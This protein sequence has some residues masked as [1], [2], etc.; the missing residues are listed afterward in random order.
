MPG[1][2]VALLA[3]LAHVVIVF[4]ATVLISANRR[5]AAAIAWVLTIVF[6]PLVGILVFLLV[7]FGRLP[8]SRRVKQREVSELFLARTQ[9]STA[10]NRADWPDWLGSA[11]QLNENLGALPMVGGNS[12]RLLEDYAGS[13]AAMA[14][15]IDTATDRVHV[16]FYI[17][18]SDSETAPV[19]D[20][21]R[22]A[23]ERGVIVR[24]LSD[25]VSGLLLPRRRETRAA[26]EM[27]GAEWL[28]MLPLRPL[29]GQWQRADMRNHRKLLVVD[30]RIGFT[31][32]Q[33]LIAASYLKPKNLRRGLRWREL[34]VEFEG[35]VVPELD[36][37]FITDWYSETGVLLPLESRSAPLPGPVVASPVN[38]QVVPSGPSFEND[39]N[40]KLFVL[41]LHQAQSR[42]S[43]T[44]PYFVPEESTLL[45]IVT[46]ASRG[47][48]V[49]LFVSEIGDQ[50]LVHHAQR[51]YY[52]A[53]LKAGVAIYLYREP[54]VLH[55]KHFTI[56]NDVAVIGSSNMDIRS[57]SINME[58]S[59][60]LHGHDIVRRMRLVEDDYRAQS[61]RLDLDEWLARPLG[62]KIGDNLA[63]LTSALQ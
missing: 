3:L 25:H 63:R 19:F 10:Q 22:R 60:L 62:Q 12:A 50:K 61:R 5:P 47:V 46:A 31:G 20:A 54:T 30:G 45:A 34:M 55:S 14:A 51:S 27:M 21:L 13:I 57:F 58:V 7:G 18:V 42:I 2:T 43:I 48:E 32:S 24:A 6:V 8:P 15:A 35:P 23:R 4:V 28:P 56:D 44:S 17:L 16:Q 39:N 41:M 49:E 36:A 29:R 9:G 59:V 26:F 33:N 37:V 53:L 38:A 1:E 40:L 11:A 52:E